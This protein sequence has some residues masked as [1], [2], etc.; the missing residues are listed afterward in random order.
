MAPCSPTQLL[1]PALSPSLHSEGV[2]EVQPYSASIGSHSGRRGS[3]KS[4]APRGAWHPL[5]A[6]GVW[7]DS[8]IPEWYFNGVRIL[9]RYV[10]GD[11]A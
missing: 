3:H 6:L 10:Y 1:H 11:G 5:F 7:V 4:R 8:A 2:V 9:Y